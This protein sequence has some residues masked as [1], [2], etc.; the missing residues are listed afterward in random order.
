MKK[1]LLTII[2]A[3]LI[4]FL[5]TKFTYSQYETDYSLKTVFNN[6]EELI[7]L[8]YKTVQSLDDINLE[9]Y[10]Y[11]VEEDTYHIYIGIT[12]SNENAE[13]LKEYFAKKEYIVN[14]V[15]IYVDNKEFLELIKQYDALL[16]EVTDDT[17]IETI[18]KTILEKYKELVINN[19]DD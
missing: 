10:I 12:S 16:K 3:I 2:L 18:N 15:S 14:E 1:N 13:K 17:V 6:N 19:Y 9:N 11:S 4:G 8:K 5:M 7:F